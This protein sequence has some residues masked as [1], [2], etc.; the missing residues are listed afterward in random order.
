M[1]DLLV[2]AGALALLTHH[3]AYR[4]ART[5]QVRVH[6]QFEAEGEATAAYVVSRF[7]TFVYFGLVVAYVA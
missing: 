3:W 4:T 7:L 6:S 1:T 5:A 2:L